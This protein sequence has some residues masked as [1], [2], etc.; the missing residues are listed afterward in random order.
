MNGPEPDAQ[1]TAIA[2]LTAKEREC[3]RLWLEHKTAKEIAL[4]LG[5]SHHAVEKRLKSA[6]H[7]LGVASSLDAA[8]LMADAEGYGR[9][10]SGSPDLPVSR[11]GADIGVHVAPG[12]GT[13]GLRRRILSVPGVVLMSILLTAALFLAGEALAPSADHAAERHNDSPVAALFD[14]EEIERVMALTPEEM[15]ARLDTDGSGVLEA[16]EVQ[17]SEPLIGR[18][19]VR[20][21]MPSSDSAKAQGPSRLGTF[22]VK[23]LP[24]ADANADGRIDLAEYVAWQTG[25]REPA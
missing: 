11:E 22:E 18:Y 1:R 10:A 25:A 13:T 3:L 8:R 4:D 6:R 2:R 15:F 24:S 21:T 9:T 17:S 14:K 12:Q 23:S 16:N 19:S 7:K 5:I 20:Q